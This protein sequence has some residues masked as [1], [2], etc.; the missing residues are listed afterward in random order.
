[1]SGLGSLLR[2]HREAAGLTQEELADRAGVSTR[3]ISD[4]ERGLRSRIYPDTARRIGAALGLT[5]DERD[6]FLDVA[7][8]RRGAPRETA[9]DPHH[10]PRP[11]TPLVGRDRELRDL[12]DA[13]G[14]TTATRL[15]TITGL[16]GIGKT[17]LALAAAAELE[18]D[19]RGRVYFLPV[20]A[21]QDPADL[22]SA[23][24][25]ALGAPDR[26]SA[27]A[28]G[29]HL[30][31]RPALLLIDTFE[32]VLAAAGEVERILSAVDPLR[33]LATSRQRLG[34]AGEREIA[35]MP[36]AVPEPS[37]PAW[38]ESAAAAMFLERVKAHSPDLRLD[39]VAVIDICR[40]LSGV[41]LALE[42]AAARV[43]HLPLAVLRD[44]LQRGMGDLEDTG[45]GLQ[46]RHRSMEQVLAWSTGTLEPDETQVLELASLFV[47]GWRLD[48]LQRLCPEDLD[49]VRAISGLVD[50]SLAFLDRSPGAPSDVPR[51]RMLDVVREF[52]RQHASYDVPGDRRSAYLAFYADLVARARQQVGRESEWFRLLDAEEPNIRT[53][54][55]WAEADQDAEGVLG[56]AGGMWQ[57]WLARGDLVEGRRWL[58]TGLS[59]QPPARET[60]RMTAWWGMGW[61][62]YHQGDDEAAEAAAAELEELARRGADDGALRNALTIQGMVAISHDRPLEAARLLAEAL[63]L[64][65]SLGPGWILATSLLNLGLAH[66]AGDDVPG[67]RQVLAE[68]LAAYE[69]L[70]DERFRARC[71]GYLGL[72]SLLEDDPTRARALFRQSLTRFAELGEPEGTAEG[73]TGIAAVDAATGSAVR[74]ARLAG[75]GERLHESYA[76]RA[77]P[78]E[79]RATAGYLSSAERHLGAEAWAEEW[80]HG[81]GLPVADAVDLALGDVD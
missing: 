79:R 41:P 50:R 72:A 36:L 37:D 51:W 9:S 6:G 14:R 46:P 20:A 19:Y 4:I 8:G 69:E 65:R 29:T 7:R 5:N 47:A 52:V 75:A 43:R 24:A 57:F 34:V 40:G 66:L 10:V 78:L 18:P 35:L 64:A 15:V 22:T 3:A 68:A 77:L 76:G 61:L 59:F 54:L 13:L 16:G 60:T 67:A 81:R 80:R 11:L 70:G 17:R 12:V 2:R 26:T 56:L 25:R 21:N 42:L 53:A 33:V 71:L 58:A 45:R 48:A 74:A 39:P 63:R 62:A 38:A 31:G 28:W 55:T 73:L 49:V 30:D 32:H 44:R 1:M 27:E 23:V